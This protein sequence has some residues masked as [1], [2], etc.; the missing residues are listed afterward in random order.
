MRGPVTQA[1]GGLW[2]TAGAATLLCLM[3]SAVNAQTGRVSGSVTDAVTGAPVTG[4]VV[5]FCANSTQCT[6]VTVAANGTYST[7][8]QAGTYYAS[9]NDF[10]TQGLINAWHDGQ[11]CPG[12]CDG[13]SRPGTLAPLTITLTGRFVSFQLPHGGSVEGRVTNALS[14]APVGGV[15]VRLY[16]ASDHAFVTA[17]RSEV[18]GRLRL[19]GLPAGTYMASA[20]AGPVGFV[21]QIHAGLPCVA[22]CQA[23]VSG[24]P[25]TV[26][27]GRVSALDFTLTPG[28]GIAG[29]IVDAD[30]RQPIAG[31]FV[32]SVLD[33]GDRGISAA[34]A[35]T[36]ANGVY[37]L[38]GLVAGRYRLVARSEGASGVIYGGEACGALEE[39]QIHAIVGRGE[40]VEVSAGLSVT[41]RDFALQR[42]EAFDG[43]IIDAGTGAPVAGGNVTVYRSVSGRAVRI[44]SVPVVQGE[45]SVSGLPEG[46]YFAD[47]TSDDH[48]PMTL[49]GRL[50]A[51]TRCS[52]N[53]VEADAPFAAGGERATI[54]INLQT[55]RTGSLS[56]TVTADDS[57]LPLPGAMATV[58]V[59]GPYTG[60][61]DTML[62]NLA[63]VATFDGVAPGTY[64]VVAGGP[65]R[66]TELY[67]DVACTATPVCTP[68]E[69]VARGR[70]VVVTS[71][72][73][74]A[75]TMPLAPASGAPYTPW[76][77]TTASTAGM[78]TITPDPTFLGPPA[79]DFLLEAGPTPGATAVVLP[80]PVGGVTIPGVPA[81]RYWL[82]V[83]ARNA[84]GTSAPSEWT[85][86]EVGSGAPQPVQAV[87]AFV[88]GPR[89]VMTW[90]SD[91]DLVP[92]TDYVVEAGS[93]PGLSD[94]ARLPVAGRHFTYDPVPPGVYFLRVRARN[95]AG[96]SPVFDEQML[97]VGDG[98]APPRRPRIVA[99]RVAGSTVS[100]TWQPPAG[101]ADRYV[102]EA[103]TA[104]GLSDIG[105]FDVGASTT[106][107][108]TNVP[109]GTYF[110]RIRARNVRGLGLPTVDVPVSIP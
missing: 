43:R 12:A 97:V 65:G 10:Q 101:G 22:D 1:R 41:N 2:W 73:V 64:S 3:A 8:L 110:V 7:L 9:T 69:A 70:A 104:F 62:T 72:T 55:P 11:V 21:S 47:F 20:Y 59:S 38:V 58:V 79:T 39:C 49:R 54:I 66:R 98:P 81:G 5:R 100:L 77:P 23:V 92:P 87:E 109:P 83:R 56:V 105:T 14:A 89:L 63:G 13:I 82:R 61:V 30:T 29:R 37:S 6:T 33:T 51:W 40:A 84:A 80:L 25:I 35:T 28:G 52:T 53:A 99:S 26:D 4:G 102:L 32:T 85:S 31:A 103:G 15:F 17:S 42:R 107:A 36:D 48:A 94:I 46:Q 75:L 24:D 60:F 91:E 19:Q 67:D 96:L 78:V 74:T 18:T 90:N 44:G 108:A 88:T 93:A 86:F 76:P 50:C 34:V 71:S 95:S 27:I 57:G 45:F 16:R 68:A 106:F